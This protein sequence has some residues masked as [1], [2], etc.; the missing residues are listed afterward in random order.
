MK[1]PAVHFIH[2]S[3]RLTFSNAK[4]LQ[5]AQN[6]QN[7]LEV[8]ERH[9][10]SP[11]IADVSFHDE[12]PAAKRLGPSLGL[13]LDKNK[14]VWCCKPESAKDPE[15]KLLLNSYDHAWATVV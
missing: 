8:D 14:C 11:S 13:I 7:K 15:S 6:R 9:S 5:Q 4:K 1:S 10:Q 3:Y 2:D 12:V